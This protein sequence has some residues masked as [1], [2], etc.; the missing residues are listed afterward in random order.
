LA[1][2]NEIFMFFHRHRYTRPE[3]QMMNRQW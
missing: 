1:I 2:L 3:W